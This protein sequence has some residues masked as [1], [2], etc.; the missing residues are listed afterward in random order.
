MGYRLPL[1]VKNALVQV[2]G[3]A[4]WY[5]KPLFDAF[6]RAGIREDLYLPYED[7]SK[8][9]I[10]RLVLEHLEGDTDEGRIIQR[11]LVTVFVNLKVDHRAN[12]K[13]DHL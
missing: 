8:Y 13:V 7:E 6:V 5:K 10:A 11:R 12:V 2:C 4:F 9:K 1:D 3:A